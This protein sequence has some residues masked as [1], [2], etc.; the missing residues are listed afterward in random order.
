MKIKQ[1]S[2]YGFGKWVDKQFDLSGGGVD[3]L[4][5]YNESGKSTLMAFITAIFFGFPSKR[6]HQYRPRE[7]DKYGGMITIDMASYHGI[8]I[9]RVG[10]RTNKGTLSVHYPDG[11]TG[12]EEDLRKLLKGIDAVTFKGIFHFD[13]DGLQGMKDL[14]PE[15]LN[16]YL[17]DAGML[18]ASSL[19]QLNK[20]LQQVSGKLFKPK[21]QKTALNIL[22]EK[23]KHVQQEVKEWEHKLDNYEA[24]QATKR[25]LELELA[26]C[27]N[28]EKKCRIDMRYFDHFKTVEPIVKEWHALTTEQKGNLKQ[29]D[30][31]EDGLSRLEQ[32]H[33]KLEEKE[34]LLAHEN[35][36]I[37][38]LTKEF[39]TLT[40]ATISTDIKRKVTSVITKWSLQEKMIEDLKESRRTEQALLI[41]RNQIEDDWQLP[42]TFFSS[43]H[44]TNYHLERFNLLKSRWQTLLTTED[45][46]I[47]EKQRIKREIELTEEQKNKEYQHLL[48]PEEVKKLERLTSSE[49]E[50]KLRE[51]EYNML[52]KQREW[53]EKE[54]YRVKR[55]G[56]RK[57][58]MLMSF[59]GLCVIGTIV[60]YVTTNWTLM[61]VLLLLV[62]ISGSFTWSISNKSRDEKKRMLQELK[63]LNREMVTLENFQRD[64]SDEAYHY[65][66]QRLALHNNKMA[67]VKTLNQNVTFL[68]NQLQQCETEWEALQQKWELIN[69][70]L[71]EWCENTKMPPHRD[72]LYYDHLIEALKEWQ[73]ITKEYENVKKNMTQL[74]R[75]VSDYKATVESLVTN[76]VSQGRDMSI[77]KQVEALVHFIEKEEQAEKSRTKV[78]DKLSVHEDLLSKVQKE[79]D[80]LLSSLT[81]LF[82]LAHVADE[83]GFRRK[84]H[85][86][87]HQQDQ[88]TRLNQL[89][90]QIVTLVP[91][92]KKRAIL[93]DDII[94]K[95][96]DSQ[97]K[98]NQL[99]ESVTELEQNKK[100][101]M[102]E[103]SSV[104]LSLKEI[105]ESG[106][107]EDKR[108][109]FIALKGEFNHLAK[110]WAVIQTAQYMIHKVKNIYETERQPK[111]IQTAC[112]LFN[113]L[114]AG[115]YPQLFAPLGE[116]RFIVERNDGQRFDPSELSRGTGELL[117]LSLRLALAIEDVMETG[118]PIIMDETFVNMDTPRRQQLISLLK[119]ISNDRQILF[120]T[121]HEHLHEEWQRLFAN[122]EIHSLHH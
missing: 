29:V 93:L 36:K 27:E 66:E 105:E 55:A 33:D 67:H 13:L 104:T 38:E 44:M 70:E 56:S 75:D 103:L 107:Y 118:S 94:N 9:E 99:Q 32:L 39:Q 106:T 42:Q 83:E 26:H 15:D 57:N 112:E 1:I 109:T 25:Q 63:S 24:L 41:Q 98:L 22:A 51:Q 65:A 90:L 23:L 115:R 120:F 108:Q 54:W 114:T 47:E 45:Y 2:I 8:M 111:V 43:A 84:A 35:E 46:L 96:I 3:L 79:R 14:N 16:H 68:N 95:N 49:N 113:R 72:L 21:G 64:M 60:G 80:Q 102:A 76:Y 88:L 20:S 110:E 117:Y 6:E 77:D 86:Y 87:N 121:C 17:Y 101:I 71:E 119:E 37:T 12:N 81:N 11:R 92:E 31:P 59:T 40:D 85:Q 34:A 50:K 61:L 30:F 10:G 7:T 58:L 122:V 4:F 69:T 116:E 89:W 53:L 73:G 52:F 78:C 74:N 28:E 18:G 91:N 62:M 48:A 97:E 5:G 82:T 100:R 19:N